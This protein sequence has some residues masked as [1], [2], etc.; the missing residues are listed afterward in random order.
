[1]LRALFFSCVITVIGAPGSSALAQRAVQYDTVSE[2]TPAAVSCGF[3]AGEKFGIVFRPLSE[4]RGLRADEFPLV[5]NTMQIAVARAVV[6]RSGSFGFECRGSTDMGSVSMML[7]LYAGETPPSGSIVG[8]PADGPWPTETLVFAESAELE[9]SVETTAGS[10]MYNVM[11]NTVNVDMGVRVPQPNTYLRA[12]VTIPA[13]GMSDS[14]SDL[15]LSGPGA[16]GIRDND[17]RIENEVSFIFARNPFDEIIGISEGWHW[18]EDP[19][20]TDDSGTSGINGDWAIRLDVNPM[21]MT[22]TDAG[23]PDSGVMDPDSGMSM[24]MDSG[25]T[26]P[27]ED[28]GGTP[29]CAM[30]ADC[31]GGERCVEGMCRRVTCAAASDCAGGMTCV[32]GM[33]RNLCTSS[34][35][36]MGGE[37]CDDAAGYCV[38]VGEE[39]GGGCGCRV[40]A[41]RS[42]G[43]ALLLPLFGLLLFRRRG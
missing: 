5:V 13:G 27:P 11:F 37:V 34:A 41:T 21:G 8:N 24:P 39:S 35:E 33:C 10:S 31:A 28:G 15:M 38:P 14:C 36:C 20:I 43:L 1:M 6:T 42:A 17:G 9:V 19:E 18:N 16:V 7:E 26:P 32:E 3:C 25:T 22:M 12:V 2:T 30:D 4:G 40:G 29:M 23:M